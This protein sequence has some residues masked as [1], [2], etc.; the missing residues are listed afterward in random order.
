MINGIDIN[1]S[2]QTKARKL[3]LVED[4]AVLALVEKRQLEQNGYRVRH[5]TKG[6]DAVKHLEKAPQETDL[7][8]M[9]IDLGEGIDGTQT[10]ERILKNH[11]IPILFLSSHT[12]KEIV[13]KTEKISS[14]G[15][16]V[17]NS[18]ITVLDASI[19]M[20]F[21]LFEAKQKEAVQTQKLKESELRYRQMFENH[22]AVEM[23]IHPQS[24]NII[25][26]NQ[27]ALKFYGY[28]KEELLRKS[29]FE[30]NTATDEEIKKNIE[31]VEKENN[32]YF[33]FQHRVADGSVKNVNV[34]T[35]KVTLRGEVLLHSIVFDVTT[36]IQN[37]ENTI[38]QLEE[39]RKLY[40]T[41]LENLPIG[42][43]VN[44]ISDNQ[45]IL[46]NDN[47]NKI[48]RTEKESVTNFDSFFEAVYKSE[49]FRHQ[50]KARIIEDLQTGNPERMRWENIP[51]WQPDSK[52]YAYVSA[53]NIPV[54]EHDMMIS[55]VLDVTDVNLAKNQA[56]YWHGF[57]NYVLRHS[58]SPVAI[59]NNRMQYIFVSDSYLDAFDLSGK[60]ILGKSH[61]EIFPEMPERFKQFHQKAL[62][63][64]VISSNQDFFIRE[65]GTIMFTSWVY[66]PWYDIKG[67]IGGVILYSEIISKKD[68]KGNQNYE[69][70]S[71]SKLIL[72]TLKDFV[73]TLNNQGIITGMYGKGFEEFNISLQECLGKNYNEI[74]TGKTKEIHEHY[75]KQ[76]LGGSEVTYE[77]AYRN[78]KDKCYFQ[79]TFYPY[80]DPDN[81]LQVLFGFTKNI[82]ELKVAQKRIEDQLFK[83]NIL[84]KELYHRIHNNLVGIKGILYLK[85]TDQPSTETKEFI[86]DLR[87]RLE[88]MQLI[89]RKLSLS[90]DTKVESADYLEELAA[91]ILSTRNLSDVQ[92][93]TQLENHSVEGKKM[94]AVGIITN[95]L[96]TNA[97][98]YAF[99]RKP[100]EIE[101]IFKKSGHNYLLEVADNGV[102]L[103][104]EIDTSENNCLGL[105]L[106]GMLTQQLGGNCQIIRK[107]GTRF[108]I[109]F[110]VSN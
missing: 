53:Y 29:I 35:S 73:V 16:V 4:E 96:M 71:L 54:H 70:N 44:T 30:I 43:A 17:K 42:I 97:L 76:A 33:E 38:K 88:N 24:G 39:S 95:E 68:L 6:E 75:I 81:H 26:A 106:V 69:S 5:F 46:T 48:Y 40:K 50:I 19:K 56:L 27:Q 109:T 11:D 25:D 3:L 13:E 31:K 83:K 37:L 98:K 104:K 22:S 65:N 20:A 60:Q 74:F 45:I 64:E 57:L 89:Y 90:D 99:K 86:K 28:S 59:F 49:P 55:T 41:T 107:N 58:K 9:D 85:L 66:R 93:K 8:L 14:Y 102:G 52:E 84:L 82:T 92:L 101:V 80:T 72:N 108:K 47:F 32:A 2:H 67:S 103:P 79:T 12:E 10:A 21:K 63:G 23:I 105:T 62:K 78:E 34:F 94:Y 1:G 51:L 110:P 15:Y 7:I 91:T 18:S 87:I 36:H 77:W 100:K 61:Y